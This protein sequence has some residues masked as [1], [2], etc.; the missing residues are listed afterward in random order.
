MER[1]K[2]KEK[3]MYQYIQKSKNMI[4]ELLSK[5]EFQKA[6]DTIIQVISKMD[7]KYVQD[8]VK[9]YDEESSRYSS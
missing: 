3:E 5:N 9:H 2:E 6:F 1:E 4:D 8:F 7:K